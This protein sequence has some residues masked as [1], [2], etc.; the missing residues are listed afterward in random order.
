MKHDQPRARL[1]A[2]HSILLVAMALFPLAGCESSEAASDAGSAGGSA[3]EAN[4]SGGSGSNGT[5]GATSGV[6]ENG[7]WVTFPIE[8]LGSGDPDEPVVV[9][10]DIPLGE[11]VEPSSV[12]R[13]Y[14][15]CH[16]CGFYDSPEF[17]KLDK[18]LTKVKTSLRIVGADADADAPWI[19]VTDENV[20]LD[21]V[22]AA[23][24]GFQGGLITTTFTVTIDETTRDRLGGSTDVNRVEFRF[25]G[26]DGN[27]NGFRVLDVRFQDDAGA[28]LSPFSLKWADIGR[29][30]SDSNASDADIEAGEALWHARG[31]LTKSPIVSHQTL[32]AACSD[33]H[34]ADGRDLQYFNYSN[35]SIAQRSRFHGLSQQEGE[36]IAAYIRSSQYSVPHVAAAAPWNPPYQPGPGLDAKPSVEWAA[37]AGLDAVLP[38]GAAF[39]KAFVG[40]DVDDSPLAVSQAELDAAHSV[41]PQKPLNT[42]EMPVPLQFPDWNAWLPITHPL[43]IWTPDEGQDAGLFE[44][45]APDT[46]NPQKVY[47]RIMTWLEEH[48]NPNGT[49]GDWSH[50]TAAERD[51]MQFW[52]NDLGGKSIAFGG[53]GRGT[54][55][56]G[57]AANPFGGETG[58]AKLEAL[59]DADTQALAEGA[60]ALGFSKQ[61]FIERALFGLFHWMG[62]K[63]WEIANT[64]GVEGPQTNFRGK[65]DGDTWTGEGE[66]RGWPYSWPSVFYMAPHMLYAPE[67]KEG[68]G[69]REFYFSWEPRFISYYRT[70]QWYQLQMTLNP[71]WAGASSG[72]MDWPYH[73]GFTTGLAS[74][75]IENGVP[76]EVT[77]AHLARY[78]QIRVKLAQ[79]ANTNISFNT[80]DAN[81]PNN[82]FK[83]T[84]MNSKADL[85]FK[86][87]VAEI[88]HRGAA[89]YQQ[90]IFTRLDAIEPGLHVMFVSSAVAMYNAFFEGSTADQWRRCDP[91]AMMFGDSGEF[92]SKSGQRF[93]LDAVRTPLPLDENDQ[94]YLP[95]GWVDWTTEQHISW[96]ILA[97]RQLGVEEARVKVLEDWLDSQY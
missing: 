97:A 44:A 7:A 21:P 3:G 85:L 64:Y 30:K 42:R 84:G 23:H 88:T 31:S 76:D 48:K 93:C 47:E 17:Q 28:V 9:G 69:L 4:G 71:G 43:D 95:G 20:T 80:P 37:G 86:L 49:Y 66:V 5:G 6:D 19:D 55:Q 63:Q 70:N 61:A 14:V 75:L 29:E 41:D 53:G 13:L 79:L 18:P 12:S 11:G 26:T 24:G 1:V 22:S 74:D 54:R 94:P 39:V 35:H 51:Q 89:N 68:G 82:L 16:R 8:V 27:S 56:S 90:T 81:E 58:G 87:G 59:L 77:A 2:S 60:A 52:F 15:R 65:R 67:P 83:N 57:D 40:R 32:R 36:Q 46:E 73:M 91:N 92:E 45:K 38:S 25:N 78:F 62:V 10:R 34:A 33:C 50:L 72:P 96:G